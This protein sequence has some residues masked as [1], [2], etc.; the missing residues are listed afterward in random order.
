MCLWN[1]YLAER[2]SKETELCEILFANLERLYQNAGKGSREIV[3]R[4]HFLHWFLRLRTFLPVFQKDNDR[5][6]RV[7]MGSITL[8]L[9]DM[10]IGKEDAEFRQVLERCLKGYDPHGKASS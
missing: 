6:Q 10:A 4:F 3:T 8:P 1:C 2:R 5:F 9:A 7:W